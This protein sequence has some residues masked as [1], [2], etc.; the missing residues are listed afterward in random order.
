VILIHLSLTLRDEEAELRDRCKSIEYR[1]KG[2]TM[3]L[4][5]NQPGN[6]SKDPYNRLRKVHTPD[7]P[8]LK[9]RGTL[10]ISDELLDIPCH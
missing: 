3:Q 9:Q 8:G 4:M 2:L 7:K 1:Y 5:T 10:A 6:D